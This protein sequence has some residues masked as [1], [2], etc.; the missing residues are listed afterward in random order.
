MKESDI[1]L[2][3]A[4]IMVVAR[5][6]GI[7]SPKEDFA[8]GEITA[9]L[10]AKK[11]DISSAEKLASKPN[12]QPTPVGCYSDQIRNIEDMV[13]LSL[14]DG[15]LQDSEKK[16][17]VTFAKQIGVVQEQIS[18]ILSEAKLR[19]QTQDSK[20]KCP[21]CNCEISSSAKFCPQCGTT[22]DTEFEKRGTKIEFKYSSQGVSIE[23]AESSSVNFDL[24]LSEARKAPNFQ[25]C[26]RSKKTW[27]LATW[28]KEQVLSVVKLINNLKGIRNRK[29]YLDGKESS[30]DELF[31]FTWCLQ[32]RQSAYKP[33]EYCFGM[34]ENRLNLWGCKQI[35]MDWT[36]WA[37]WF[38][39]G[40][41]RKKDIF[42]FN[43]EK[44]WHEL[45]NNIHKH[46]LCPFLRNN[47]IKTIFHLLP[48]EVRVSQ[49]NRWKYKKNYE[50]TIDSIK[51]IQKEKYDGY[52]TTDEFYSDGV[53]PIGFEVARD[54]LKKAFKSCA[55]DD[56]DIKAI[57]P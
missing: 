18:R 25:E 11:K 14:S 49:K 21:K 31:G 43:K 1:S 2:Y 56:V 41:F 53:V 50:Q 26:I 17:I 48:N 37:R 7:L 22:I 40:N 54:M 16:I 10:K 24:A 20:V 29:A 44:I 19:I 34:D 32:A 51:I 39:Y 47:L 52:T 8:L 38:S 45:S 4:N 27:F 36:E 33:T 55:I 46:R 30:W 15:K 5:A 12:Y 35:N 23:F 13:F 9:S 6:D 28:P 57:V 3:L 42:V